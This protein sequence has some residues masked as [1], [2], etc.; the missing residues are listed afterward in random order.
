MVFNAKI[1]K[2]T[3][4]AV[5]LLFSLPPS[6]ASASTIVVS[7][8]DGISLGS[9]DKYCASPVKTYLAINETS[10]RK[11]ITD[12]FDLVSQN[13]FKSVNYDLSVILD[14]G[15]DGG[16]D[17]TLSTGI[18]SY[19]GTVSSTE[20]P[21]ADGVVQTFEV[22]VP[23][24]PAAITRL[25]QDKLQGKVNAISSRLKSGELD[26][27]QNNF[28]QPLEELIANF[29]AT[30]QGPSLTRSS[31]HATI[32]AY[33]FDAEYIGLIGLSIFVLLMILLLGF[34]ISIIIS[35]IRDR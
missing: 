28:N 14:V 6:I 1:L 19:S 35:L 13:S 23:L 22:N 20:Q 10:M 2:A 17:F 31:T 26:K 9:I 32:S 8:P 5:A 12:R 16:C 29:I 25:I 21:A 33:S 7:M 24:L 4:F 11:D 34:P 30:Y 18:I 15:T 27:F 3:L